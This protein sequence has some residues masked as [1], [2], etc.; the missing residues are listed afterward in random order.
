MPIEIT[1]GVLPDD[2]AEG[3]DRE[4]GELFAT[5]QVLTTFSADRE[6]R[7]DFLRVFGEAAACRPLSEIRDVAA[8]LH[9]MLVAT[10]SA[11]A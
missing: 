4:P 1:F 11:H 5:L 7:D 10:E 6:Q 3:F 9:Q 8:L 2:M